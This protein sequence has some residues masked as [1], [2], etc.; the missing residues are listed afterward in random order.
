MMVPYLT[1]TKRMGPIFVS[2]RHHQ[3]E[4][5]W[6]RLVPALEAG[7]VEVIIDRDR[8]RAGERV[9]GQMDHEQ[10]RADAT[11]AV[12]TPQYRDSLYCMH[13]L[14]RAVARHK[15]IPV[16]QEECKIPGILNDPHP[17]LHVDLQEPESPYAWGDLLDACEAPEW[18]LKIDRVVRFLERGQSVNL[19]CLGAHLWKPFLRRVRQRITN[20]GEVDLEDGQATTRQSLVQLILDQFGYSGSVPA[21]GDLVEFSRVL[22]M[23]KESC[24]LALLHFDYAPR[25]KD[26]EHDFFASVRNL[27]MDSRKL[28]LLVQSHADFASLL[29]GNH[30]M[31]TMDIKTVELLSRPR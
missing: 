23:K 6:E 30:P 17:I 11:I 16:V 13:E 24:R 29:P 12:L 28:V 9:V 25:R 27:V 15:V 14:E 21:R 22:T 8:F 1:D 19:V 18:T 7:G 31:S 20:L 26:Y 10:D 4:W 2:Y 3:R 5:V